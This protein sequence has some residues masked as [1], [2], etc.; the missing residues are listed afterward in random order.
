MRAGVCCVY[1]VSTQILFFSHANLACNFQMK[2]Y[3]Q[4]INIPVEGGK[5]EINQL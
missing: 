1:H 2:P 5:N 3:F 4:F